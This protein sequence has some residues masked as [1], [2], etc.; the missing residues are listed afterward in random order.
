VTWNRH[1]QCCGTPPAC[2]ET[3]MKHISHVWYM[4]CAGA[5]LESVC[6][7]GTSPKHPMHRWQNI[8]CANHCT[9]YSEIELCGNVTFTVLT[10]M[11][12]AS[13]SS[14]NTFGT[15]S[16]TLA[17]VHIHRLSFAMHEQTGNTILVHL[18]GYLQGVYITLKLLKYTCPRLQ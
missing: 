7:W 10:D 9:Q 16:L 15:T 11:G 8:P 17:H 1:L 5:V 3:Y 6:P 2:S 4:E 18:K 13:N 14:R 12:H